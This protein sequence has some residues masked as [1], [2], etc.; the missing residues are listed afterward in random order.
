MADHREARVSQGGEGAP[1]RVTPEEARRILIDTL[2]AGRGDIARQSGWNIAVESIV[3]DLRDENG[4]F[5]SAIGQ[6][7]TDAQMQGL[8]I[9]SMAR[10]VRERLILELTPSQD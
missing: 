8:G 3:A 2:R 1:R 5:D 4:A 9:V 6:A 10:A 7:I